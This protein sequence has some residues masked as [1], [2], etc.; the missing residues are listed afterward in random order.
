MGLMTQVEEYSP[1]HAADLKATYEKIG[2]EPSEYKLTMK[3]RHYFAARPSDKASDI[4][5]KVTDRFGNVF[6]EELPL[7]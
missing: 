5:I 7:R 1:L 6:T 3:S 4:K 2:R